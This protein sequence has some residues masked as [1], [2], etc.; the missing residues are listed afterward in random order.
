MEWKKI[1]GT[2]H[3]NRVLS[4]EWRSSFYCDNFK[5]FVSESS[6]YFQRFFG[7]LKNR[8][9]EIKTTERWKKYG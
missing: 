9:F 6:L 8:L 5:S 1:C 2:N 3:M 4:Y 7:I